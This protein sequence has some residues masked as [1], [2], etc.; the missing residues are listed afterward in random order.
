MNETAV[1]TMNVDEY[2]LL[3]KLRDFVDMYGGIDTVTKLIDI[4]TDNNNVIKLKVYEYVGCFN[5]HWYSISTD[6]SEL[7]SLINNQ[8]EQYKLTIE[9][10]KK[11][12]DNTIKE[13]TKTIAK[14][15]VSEFKQ[16]K[17]Q[18]IKDNPE[19]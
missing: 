4:I 19:T 1:V 13:V 15:S 17:K 2:I 16:W 3:K 8:I 9:D 5:K 18:Y 11:I 14:K 12:Y 10:N 7:Q 6:D